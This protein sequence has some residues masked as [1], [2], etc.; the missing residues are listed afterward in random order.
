MAKAKETFKDP[1]NSPLLFSFGVGVHSPR[2]DYTDV[3][4]FPHKLFMPVSFVA[5]SCLRRQ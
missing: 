4:C 1:S 2:N 5:N 3:Y